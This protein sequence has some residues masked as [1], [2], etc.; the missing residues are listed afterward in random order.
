M[1]L[2]FVRNYIDRHQVFANQ[3]LHL[4]GVPLTF[5]VSIVLL[6]L[7]EPG[8]AA[9]AFVTGYVLQFIGHGIEGNDA[10]E[11][12]LVKKLLGKPYREFRPGHDPTRDQSRQVQ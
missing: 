11:M 7:G 4:V 1:L 6:V 2:R 5:V 9:G 8:R 3:L 10:G 12:I